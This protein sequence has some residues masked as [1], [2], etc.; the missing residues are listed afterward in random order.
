MSKPQS[1]DP[2]SEIEDAETEAHPYEWPEAA[3]NRKSIT[4]RFSISDSAEKDDA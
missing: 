2:E 4:E 3:D 1:G